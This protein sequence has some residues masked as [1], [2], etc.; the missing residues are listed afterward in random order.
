MIIPLNLGF[1]HLFL[2]N[3]KKYLS[4]FLVIFCLISVFYYKVS[5]LDNRKFMELENV[6]LNNYVDSS[7]LH[8]SLSNLK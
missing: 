4:S 3:K 6:N 2:D 1:S 8:P 7:N 5:Y